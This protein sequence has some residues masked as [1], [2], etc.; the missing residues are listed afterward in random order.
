M[1]VPCEFDYA[2]RYQKAMNLRGLKKQ[3]RRKKVQALLNDPVAPEGEKEAARAALK[4][5]E[6]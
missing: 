4:R 2:C 5:M 1:Y 3:E 6:G